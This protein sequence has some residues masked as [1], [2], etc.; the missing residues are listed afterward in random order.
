MPTFDFFQ[1]LVVTRRTLNGMRSARPTKTYLANN[2]HNVLSFGL[3]IDAVRGTTPTND[4]P[5]AKDAREIVFPLARS[6]C[7]SCAS[8]RSA[9]AIGAIPFR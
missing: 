2:P 7:T 1:A 4:D 5:V 3:S 9:V 6:R 8:V